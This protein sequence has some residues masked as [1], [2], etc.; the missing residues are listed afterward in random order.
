MLLTSLHTHT[1]YCDGKYSAEE[2]ILAAIKC[3]MKSI[4]IST[5]GPT[6]FESDWNIKKASIDK[7]IMEINSLKEKYKDL[8]EIYLGMELDYIPGIGFDDTA[9]DLMTKLDYYIGSVHYLGK[10][11]NGSMWTVDYNIEELL[12]GINESF[13]GD[14]RLAVEAY[15]SYIG[16]MAQKYEP[17][18]I[19]HLD[20][21]KKN[22]KNNILF[23]EQ[24]D[25]YINAVDKCL[26]IIKNTS[27]II[28]I[29]TG[30]IA[31]GY[32]KEQYPSTF[33]LKMIRN[34]N[35]PIIINSDAHT[36][37]SLLCKYDEMYKLINDIKFEKVSH[38]SKDGWIEELLSI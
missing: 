2:M 24:E 11:K 35:I 37:D 1:N 21:I 13:G 9:R 17:P 25:W 27:S 31:R 29:N 14:I 19:G 30:G 26:D 7:Y 15:Y 33:I 8:I 5:H 12:Q 28:E 16:E 4:G 22:N 6:P 23:N 18:I 32:V 10:F 20:L 36:T 3:N 34:K 38:L